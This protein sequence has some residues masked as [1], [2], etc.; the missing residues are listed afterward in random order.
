MYILFPLTL[1]THK[2]SNSCMILSSALTS[3]P[4]RKMLVM[5]REDADADLN[6]FMPL[7]LSFLTFY[8]RLWWYLLCIWRQ[9]IL[10]RRMTGALK[11]RIVL[12]NTAL[13][14]WDQRECSTQVVTH[15]IQYERGL[16][17]SV[18][19]WTNMRR[20]HR[21]MW[22][23]VRLV[24]EISA[25]ECVKYLS[26][27]LKMRLANDAEMHPSSTIF[28][29]IC[30]WNTLLYML[31]QSTGNCEHLCPCDGARPLAQ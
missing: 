9:V 12:V 22:K 8:K 3:L 16:G 5:A 11:A 6:G 23:L 2:H 28:G 18:L 1:P 19:I 10:F 17:T 14:S 25:L 20:R 27:F 15:S 29:P 30:D 7:R 4:L 21:I 31:R 13:P 26:W 24:A